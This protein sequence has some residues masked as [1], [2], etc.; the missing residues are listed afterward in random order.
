LEQDRRWLSILYLLILVAYGVEAALSRSA[1]WKLDKI[2]QTYA[3]TWCF[4]PGAGARSPRGCSNSTLSALLDAHVEN[5]HGPGLSIAY[6]SLADWSVL[7]GASWADWDIMVSPVGICMSGSIDGLANVYSTTCRFSATNNDHDIPSV[8]LPEC[9]VGRPQRRVTD[10]CYSPPARRSGFRLSD[11]ASGILTIIGLLIAVPSLA[12]GT[13][14]L[15][16]RLRG[17]Q[18]VRLDDE[19]A[20][21]LVHVDG[22]AG[23]A[24][25]EP[26]RLGN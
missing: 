22:N 12:F 4:H 17:Q 24:R 3:G 15:Y 9:T 11:S 20:V 7:G 10:G 8:H 5:D 26:D 18:R 23:E 19:Q 1:Y 6:Y 21:P 14:R 13:Y 16:Y 2:E 25:Q